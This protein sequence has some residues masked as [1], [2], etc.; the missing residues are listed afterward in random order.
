[1]TFIMKLQVAVILHKYD[2]KV[3]QDFVY[4]D[5]WV[6]T[7]CMPDKNSEILYRKRSA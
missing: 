2:I 3:K 6:G 4:K 5:H 1:M 7:V